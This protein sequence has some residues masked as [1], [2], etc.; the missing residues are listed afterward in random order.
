MTKTT[1]R[2]VSYKEL[3]TRLPI[4]YLPRKYISNKNKIDNLL[5]LSLYNIVKMS[6]TL[7]LKLAKSKF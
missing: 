4:F 3:Q 2:V 7:V 1:K 5:A 6:M